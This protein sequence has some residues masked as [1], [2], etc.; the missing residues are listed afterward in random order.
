MQMPVT[1]VNCLLLD[2]VCWDKDRFGKDYLGEF[3]LALED[4][5]CNEHTELEPKWYPLRSKRPG[6]KKSSNVSG[7]VLL[8]FTLF[9]SL[10]ISAT[11]A[12]NLEKLR[13]LAGVVDMGEAGTPTQPTSDAAAGEEGEEGGY[14]DD[15]EEPSDETDDPT[16]PENV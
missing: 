4:V 1:N 8:Q 5:F 7:D 13:Q 16:K 2:V 6:G 15:D 10:N 14:F 12:S 9:D 3:D 11:P